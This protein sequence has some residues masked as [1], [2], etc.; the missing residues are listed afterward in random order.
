MSEIEIAVLIGSPNDRGLVRASGMYDVFGALGLEVPLHVVSCHRNPRDLDAFCRESNVDVYIAAAG[1][2]AALPGAIS[3]ATLMNKIVIGVPLDDYG[4]DTC[5]R[6]PGG[7]P[8]LTAG[9]GKAGLRN[10]ALAASQIAATHSADL[11]AKLADYLQ[12]MTRPPEFNA[13]LDS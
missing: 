4:I 5:I 7:V 8:V 9:V 12:A 2:A 13:S 1:L 11:R 10:A 6:L 3:A